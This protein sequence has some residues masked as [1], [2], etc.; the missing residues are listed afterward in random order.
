[1]AKVAI[2]PP[3]CALVTVLRSPTEAIRSDSDAVKAFKFLRPLSDNDV[4]PASSRLVRGPPQ[5]KG[6]PRPTEGERE[7]R[8]CYVML[9]ANPQKRANPASCLTEPATSRAAIRGTEHPRNRAGC[10]EQSSFSAHAHERRIQLFEDLVRA[11]GATSV[12]RGAP[13]PSAQANACSAASS[14]AHAETEFGKPRRSQAGS[15]WNR[16]TQ[17]PC[18]PK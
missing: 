10:R 5:G 4:D 1:M 8:R 14:R 9:A 12:R 13:N 2:T 11:R 3:R 17:I 16:R 18:R 6:R 15:C 7:N